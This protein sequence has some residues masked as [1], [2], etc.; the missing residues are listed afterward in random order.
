MENMNFCQ[1]CAMPIDAPGKM[2][3]EIDGSLN[4]EYCTYCYQKGVFVNP[5]MTLPEMK[6][7]VK[8]KME[9]MKIDPPIISSCVNMLPG[10]KRWRKM[11]AVRPGL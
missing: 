4:K 8:T 6:L 3:T 11:V 10:L 2:G 9:E 5:G 7:L 1:S